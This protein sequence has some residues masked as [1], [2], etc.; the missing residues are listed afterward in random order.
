MHNDIYNS[1]SAVLNHCRSSTVRV[2]RLGVSRRETHDHK[3]SWLLPFQS[4][5]SLFFALYFILYI[6]ALIL[7]DFIILPIS[8]FAFSALTPLVGHQGEHPVWKNWVMRCWCGY[9]SGVRHRLFAYGPA[10]ATDVPKPHHSSLASFKSRLV[11]PFW[12]RLT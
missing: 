9:L 2:G 8:A 12:C 3:Q 11:L 10:D 6:S 4:E 5:V 7:S 1:S